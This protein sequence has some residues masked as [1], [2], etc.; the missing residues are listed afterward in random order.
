[1]KFTMHSDGGHSFELPATT[2]VQKVDLFI[3]LITADI[4]PLPL[5][6]FILFQLQKLLNMTLSY[7]EQERS[8]QNSSKNF[9]DFTSLNVNVIQVFLNRC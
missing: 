2:S 4:I 6:H 8:K 1:M 3:V 5:Y 7:R 9:S